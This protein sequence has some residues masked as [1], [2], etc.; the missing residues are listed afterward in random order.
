[1]PRRGGGRG[2]QVRR[3]RRRRRRRRRILVGG[4]VAFG[5]YKM[6]TKD[7][8]RVK[9]HT[10]VDPEELEDDELEQAMSELGIE[11]QKVTDADVEEGAAPAPAAAPA[12]PA[13]GGGT[14][15]YVEELQKLASLRDAG[16]LTDEEF[17]AKKAQIL[18]LN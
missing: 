16:I 17:N 3:Q 8:D 1:M 4:L 14:G 12:A 6:S 15:D 10:G 11:Q 18:G 2:R 7:A 5:A 13:A 9:E